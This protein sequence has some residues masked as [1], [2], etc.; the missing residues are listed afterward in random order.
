[1]GDEFLLSSRYSMI[2]TIVYV[3]FT[4]G[5][6][7]P[8]LFPI[9]LWNLLVTWLVERYVIIYHY[10]VPPVMDDKLV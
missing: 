4:F 8:V 2:F 10:K 7:M 9:A 1:M 6:A 5:I 3:T